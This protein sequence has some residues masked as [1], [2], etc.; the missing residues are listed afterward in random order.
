M[1]IT[2][3]KTQSKKKSS[4]KF[5]VLA[6]FIVAAIVAMRLLEVDEYLSSKELRSWMDGLGI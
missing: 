4:V 1:A 3:Q 2:E 6:A 5:F